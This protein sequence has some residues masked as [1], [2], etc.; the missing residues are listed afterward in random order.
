MLLNTRKNTIVL[1][2]RGNF[3]HKFYSSSH[4]F[5][6]LIAIICWE[7]GITVLER[8]KIFCFVSEIS[9]FKL[10]RKCG[11]KWFEIPHNTGGILFCSNF[12]NRE[13]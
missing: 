1:V 4:I 2:Q 11:V 3:A 5:Y 10:A 9:Y 12:N 8:I 13:I 6:D 7:L